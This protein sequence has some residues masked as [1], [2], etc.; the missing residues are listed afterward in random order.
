MGGEGSLQTTE[1][2]KAPPL[3]G[4]RLPRLLSAGSV[5]QSQWP[6]LWHASPGDCSWLLQRSI[7]CRKA[8][9]HMWERPHFISGSYQREA[10]AKSSHFV[11][12]DIQ[13]ND[14]GKTTLVKFEARTRPKFSDSHFTASSMCHRAKASHTSCSLH[15]PS[16]SPK[17]EPLPL[18]KS[19]S[20]DF[21][22][23]LKFG[24]GVSQNVMK[25][26]LIWA[27]S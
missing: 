24:N 3:S 10:L 20:P 1:I 26:Q 19:Y 15:L 16:D 7:G 18:P 14:G 8:S 2:I 23:T 11:H 22:L 4:G 6:E 13:A 9:K 5:L 21:S 12:K 17:P 27:L 25:S